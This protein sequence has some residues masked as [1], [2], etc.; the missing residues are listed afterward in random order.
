M[1]RT[2]LAALL[3]LSICSEIY[4]QKP[5]IAVLDLAVGGDIDTS[6]SGTISDE[7]RQQFLITGKFRLIDKNN[8][9]RILAEQAFQQSG[10]T[11]I[12]CAVEIGHLLN[13]EKIVTGRLSKLGAKFILH[14]N[15]ID[16]QT[17]I[18]ENS[19]KESCTCAL[20]E[21][22]VK[23]VPNPVFTL[24]E[25]PPPPFPEVNPMPN[26]TE[27]LPVINKAVTVKNLYDLQVDSIKSVDVSRVL[28]FGDGRWKLLEVDLSDEEK[29]SL[30]IIYEKGLEVREFLTD[31][32]LSNIQFKGANPKEQYFANHWT[33]PEKTP[34]DSSFLKRRLSNGIRPEVLAHLPNLNWKRL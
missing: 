7:V 8:M 34:G 28:E 30:R 16:V 12:A 6:I 23:L 21:I 2:L 10:C 26:P 4:A 32:T 5:A 19:S 1:I 15:L 29:D 17:G 3:F 25:L 22:D 13:V 18:I 33:I 14:L 11:D 20:E 9:E 27:P 24:S 31:K